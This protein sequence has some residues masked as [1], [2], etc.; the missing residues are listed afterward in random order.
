L[1]SQG[2]YTEW[3]RGSWIQNAT[4]TEPFMPSSDSILMAM[5]KWAATRESFEQ[6][7]LSARVPVQ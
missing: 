6:K 2:Y 7:F 1:S 5:R 4:V 3:I